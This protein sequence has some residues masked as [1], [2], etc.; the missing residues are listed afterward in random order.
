MRN[1]I[2]LLLVVVGILGS[3]AVFALPPSITGIQ[4]YNPAT[5]QYDDN[6]AYIGKYLLLYGSFAQTGNTVYIN[7]VAHTPDPQSTDQL[8][9]RIPSSVAPRP[10]APIA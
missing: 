6:N 10:Q 2:I 9:V 5:G 7:G 8:N 4:G 1:K 3:G